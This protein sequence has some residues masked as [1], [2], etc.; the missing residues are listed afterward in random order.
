MNDLKRKSL[1][2]CS[3]ES[4]RFESQFDQL[5]AVEGNHSARARLVVEIT[6]WLHDIARQGRFIPLGSA[7]RRAF[8]SLLERWSSVLRRQGFYMEGIDTL[9]D[10]D[11]NA[12]VVLAIDCPYPGLD[13]YSERWRHSFFGREAHVS[14]SVAHLERQGNQI[15]LI[16]GASGSG[17]SSL[18]LAGILPRLTELHGGAWLFGPRLTPAA[19][20]LAALAEAV[21]HAIG[22]PDQTSAIESDLAAKPGE[23]PGQLAA[24]CQDKPLMLLIDQFEELFTMC[25]DAGEQSAFA[26]VLCAL[27]DPTASGTDFCCRI[28]LT[29]RTDHLGRFENDNRL[30]PLY[31][32]LIDEDNSYHLT[33]IVSGDIRRAIKEPAEKAGLHFVPA[34]LIDQL[35]NQTA[36][37]SNG[38]PLLQFALHRLWDTRPRNES[39]QPLDVITEEM[40]KALPDV[41]HALG[42]VADDL[43]NVLSPTQ[44]RVCKR[45]FLEL[46]VLDESFEEPLRRR[47]SETELR[48]VLQQRFPENRDVD[49]VIGDFLREGLLRRFGAEPHYQLEVAHEALLRHWKQISLQ[50]EG[51]DVKERLHLIKHIGREAQEWAARGNK[52]DYLSLRGE[53]L[54]RANAYAEEGWLAEGELT[55]YI[56]ACQRQEATEK[57]NEQ[58]AREE[59]QRADTAE[60][61]REAA[62]HERREQVL[63][64]QMKQQQLDQERKYKR[65]TFVAL[66]LAL[67]LAIGAIIQ[68][69]VAI[70]EKVRADENARDAEKAKE[71][72]QLANKTIDDALTFARLAQ[73]ETE[74]EKEKTEKELKVSE[75]LKLA[76]ASVNILNTDPEQ[77]LLLALQAASLTGK[78]IPHGVENA[79]HQS[80]QA[81][82]VIRTLSS[83]KYSAPIRAIA[84]SPDGTK[85]V[86]TGQDKK[87]IIW[88]LRTGRV[89]HALSGHEGEIRDVAFSPDNKLIASADNKG[90]VKLWDAAK[91]IVT[92]ELSTDEKDPVFVSFSPDRRHLV[93]TGE[94]KTATI[95]DY[96][97]RSKLF[98]LQYKHKVYHAVF[99]GDGK[100]IA[101]AENAYT[102][103]LEPESAIVI[104]NTRTGK[105]IDELKCQEWIRDIACS[106][107]GKYIAAALGQDARVWDWQSNREPIILSGHINFI[108]KIIFLSS[109]VIATASGDQT[110][111]IWYAKVGRELMTMEGHKG[112]ISSVAFNRRNQTVMTSSADGTVKEWSVGLHLEYPSIAEHE[113]GINWLAISPDGKSLLSISTKDHQAKVMIS[114]LQGSVLHDQRMLTGFKNEVYAAAFSPPKGNLIATAHEDRKVRLW[115]SATGE[116]FR[117]LGEHESEVLAV[118][119]HRN[120]KE[121]ASVS[122]DG[123]VKKWNLESGKSVSI[124]IPLEIEEQYIT[125]L[126]RLVGLVTGRPY[127]VVPPIAFDPDL[128]LICA[129]TKDEKEVPIYNIVTGKKQAAILRRQGQ[130]LWSIAFSHDGK[131][132]V[133][134]GSDNTA[135]VW[136]AHTGKEK[137]TLRGHRH[138]V[139]CAAF[140]N[141][142]ERIATASMDKT[143]R[144]WD[145]ATGQLVH[146]L[147]GHHTGVT[148]VAFSADGKLTVTG[149]RNGYTRL[150]AQNVSQLLSLAQRRVTRTLNEGECQQF[151]AKGGKCPPSVA[152]IDFYV[153][154]LESAR[155]GDFRPATTNFKQAKQLDGAVMSFD[156]KRE[157][158]ELANTRAEELILRA[159]YGEAITILEKTAKYDPANERTHFLLGSLYYIQNNWDKSVI[160]FKKVRKDS[161]DYALALSHM[162]VIYHEYLGRYEDGYQTYRL[163]LD[164]YPTDINNHMNI[165]EACLATGRWDEARN[166]AEKIL[167]ASEVRNPRD[168]EVLAMKFIVV[169]S[170][171]LQGK[172]DAAE[173][174]LHDF[175]H[176]YEDYCERYNREDKFSRWKYNGTRNFIK[177]RDMDENRRQLLLTLIGLLEKPNTDVTEAQLRAY[178]K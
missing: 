122:A 10:F 55:A 153:K 71:E 152:A 133:T 6:D 21:A 139:T 167:T 141:N 78:A 156:P 129:D 8:R 15:L 84:V 172:D 51:A 97:S 124:P 145:S 107:D 158:I 85:A 117:E 162:G 112:E 147:R 90:V 79:L 30:K 104:W 134:A 37:L 116:L 114:N 161:F 98:N 164:L 160:H 83:G 7:E 157:A 4:E 66:I 57:L 170:L 168:D 74:K 19:H 144:V 33:S 26:K 1:D 126:V 177:G 94:N 27:S 12:G 135:T 34:T 70:T 146:T 99:I 5:I 169:S 121:V 173:G 64:T 67:L 36:A 174:A 54:Q 3:G 105:V 108:N 132:V 159:R 128:I 24:L 166:R 53:R 14:S 130:T 91:G 136:N 150:Y 23:A 88:N 115:H 76:A 16:I 29:L 82:R 148:A 28:L 63:L 39:G 113:S 69:E 123:I 18:A 32:R 11:P 118:A 86:T 175:M 52:H 120:G 13:P 50:L 61:L 42:K 142:D 80:V 60:R 58:R 43:F 47:R 143:V 9:A 38:L 22:H 119:F 100:Y 102:K 20:P 165:A 62:E 103:D 140:S 48:K 65:R 155:S 17:K 40:V 171:V 49:R 87:V 106:S 41:E 31:M 101:T 110:V 72:A 111:K 96:Q 75:A 2:A 35:A 56:E 176:N 81:S 137:F 163:I 178:M 154:G 25:R 93:T 68:R 73:K 151:I 125:R 138:A 45:L 131:S 149:D 92:L 44:Q 89:E 127:P 95:W 77:G 109:G 46:V 59:K